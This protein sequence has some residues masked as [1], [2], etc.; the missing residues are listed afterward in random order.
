MPSDS[1]ALIECKTCSGRGYFATDMMG[2]G[3]YACDDCRTHE[4]RY[5]TFGPYVVLR[6][7]KA[8]LDAAAACMNEL[9]DKDRIRYGEDMRATIAE[10]FAAWNRRTQEGQQ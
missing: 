6:P 10:H 2:S 8:A 9:C 4:T 1:V 5:G 7:N 3:F